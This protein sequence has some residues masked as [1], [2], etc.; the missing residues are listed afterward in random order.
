MKKNYFFIFVNFFDNKMPNGAKRWCFTI[1]NPTGE[2]TLQLIGTDSDGAQAKLNEVE[3]MIFQEERGENGTLHWQGFLILK[4]RHELAWL[5]RNISARAHFEVTRGTNEQAR[6]YCRKDDT[7]TGGIRHEYGKYPERSP[8][9]KRDERLQDAAEEL[10]IVKEKYKRIGEIPSMTLMQ[11]GFVSAYNALT[12]DVLGPYRPNLKVLTLVG[13]PGT[14]KSYCIQKFFPDHGRALY[15]NNGVWFQNPTAPVMIFEEFAGQ[16]QLQRMLQY[17][18]PYPLALEIKGRMAPAMYELVIITS[19]TRP[20]G[21]YKMEEDGSKR[22]DAI[23]ALFDR[24]G[25]HYGTFSPSR[26]SGT[27]W[28]VPLFLQLP[29]NQEVEEQQKWV[30]MMMHNYKYGFEPIEDDD[31]PPSQDPL[32]SVPEFED[33]VPDQHSPSL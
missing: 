8:V 6:D 26:K 12:A 33:S 32:A 30:E 19:N 29:H 17:L 21:W 5:K 9:K 22:N 31:W 11:C 10:D 16:I 7:Y 24:L 3:Y 18:D 25:Y 28:D 4:N 14:G 27:Y 20:E 23:L 13:P 2:D 15:C 1:N